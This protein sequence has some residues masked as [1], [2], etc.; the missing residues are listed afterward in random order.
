MSAHD[1]SH[2]HHH[3]HSAN[4]DARRIAVVLGLICAFMAVE[5]FVGI[6]ASS[7]VLLADAI[8]ALVVAVLMLRS[9][10]GLLH[11]TGRVRSRLPPRAW[12]RTRSGGRWWPSRASSR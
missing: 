2:H 4:T 11:A 3:A 6:V 7:M 8:A 1:H 10:W 5:V 9:A 12:T